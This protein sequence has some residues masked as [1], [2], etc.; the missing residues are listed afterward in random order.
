HGD[1][2]T[3]LVTNQGST[4]RTGQDNAAAQRGAPHS[5]LTEG[6]NRNY[7]TLLSRCGILDQRQSGNHT[8]KNTVS[9]SPCIRTSK[10]QCPGPAESGWAISVSRRSSG[11]STRTGSSWF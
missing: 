4:L 5:V 6:A 1:I 3:R 11:T 2:E 8:S 10:C 9:R 7:I